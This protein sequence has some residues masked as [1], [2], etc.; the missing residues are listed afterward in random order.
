MKNGTLMTGLKDEYEEVKENIKVV[1]EQ[2]Q[3]LKKELM[4]S[5]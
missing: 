5:K 1:E 3:K 2:L 4:P